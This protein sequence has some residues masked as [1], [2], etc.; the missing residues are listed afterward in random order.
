MFMP[1]K[2]FKAKLFRL[3]TLPLC[4]YYFVY[5]IREYPSRAGAICNTV[6]PNDSANYLQLLKELRAQMDLEFPNKHKLLT[7]AVRVQPFDGPD[8]KPM[9]NV[10]AYVQYFDWICKFHNG[11]VVI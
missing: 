3:L 6:S 7:A 2:I 5:S 11:Y 9:S 4:A 10:A 8:G 1:F